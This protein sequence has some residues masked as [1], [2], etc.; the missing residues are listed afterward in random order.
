MGNSKK[1][2]QDSAG[3]DLIQPILDIDCMHEPSEN[4]RFKNG[5]PKGREK[6]KVKGRNQVSTGVAFW[7]VNPKP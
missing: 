3:H 1:I 6:E 4:K 7:A 5:Q 2:N